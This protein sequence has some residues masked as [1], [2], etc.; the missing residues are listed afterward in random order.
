[1]VVATIT[2]VLVLG[3]SSLYGKIKQGN[4]L[5]IIGSTCI[6]CIFAGC[7]NVSFGSDLLNYYYR[8]TGYV[9]WVT[10]KTIANQY[11]NG[12][13]KDGLFYIIMKIFAD[14]NIKYQLF[15]AFITTA[16][17]VTVTWFI[18]KYS[19]K[20]NISFM[21]FISL[22]W[23]QFSFT[24]LRQALAMSLCMIAMIFLIEQ[25]NLFIAV[26][27]IILAGFIHGSAWIFLIS[28]LIIKLK[29][30]IN[31][32]GFIKIT[33]LALAI[34]IFGNSLFRQVVSV[35]AWN[36]TLADYAQSDIT[37]NWSGFI[38]Q[39]MFAFVSYCNYNQ[40]IKK[41]S[42]CKELY[43][44]MTIGLA[45]QA[46]SSTVAEMFRISMYFSIASICVYPSA[47]EAIENKKIYYM[48]YY[49]SIVLILAYFLYSQKF[50]GYNPIWA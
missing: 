32:T 1:M 27:L 15:I 14:N 50:I 3:L 21:M 28:V 46:F 16:F 31:R 33:M 47:I 29:I 18:S 39:L 37:L 49:G 35:V 38:V 44:I 36:Q 20:P 13:I 19:K 8:Y 10:Y 11:R 4:V 43:S 17:I 30:S 2:L 6:I 5:P 34:A 40:T 7:R 23:L 26:I 9:P 12:I 45:F 25:K 48:M 22:S 42:Y 24:G 41:Y